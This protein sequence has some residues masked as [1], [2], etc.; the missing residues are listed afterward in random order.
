MAP[1]ASCW[2]RC[3]RCPRNG[4]R[5]LLLQTIA[6]LDLPAA[7]REVARTDAD[8][9]E[10]SDA[11]VAQLTRRAADLAE[12]ERRLGEL[13]TISDRVAMPRGAMIRRRGRRRRRRMTLVSV[14]ASAVVVVGA[15]LLVTVP[16]DDMSAAEAALDDRRQ[17][18]VGPDADETEE[19]QR[20]GASDDQLLSSPL[21]GAIAPP[22]TW[23]EVDSPPDQELMSCQTADQADPRARSVLWHSFRADSD[24][25]QRAAQIVEVSRDAAAA[26]RAYQTTIDW[27]AGCQQ[28]QVQLCR[29]LPRPR[30]RRRRRRDPVAARLGCPRPY[31]HRRGGPHRSGHHPPGARGQ[32]AQGAE[33]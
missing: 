9:L 20:P 18:D 12:L 16:P 21:L 33:P 25:R 15:G 10:E 23:R 28:P 30:P 17:V 13:R 7:A 3:R 32:P 2:T 1:T 19:P 26:R 8:A 22:A 11:A 27:Y 31:A 4:R 6:G 29:R 24:S 5:L 14:A